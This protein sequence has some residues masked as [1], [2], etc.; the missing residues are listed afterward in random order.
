MRRTGRWVGEIKQMTTWAVARRQT[1]TTTTLTP[2]PRFIVP[3]FHVHDCTAPTGTPPPRWARAHLGSGRPEPWPSRRGPGRR[4][5][6][7]P[8]GAP[9]LRRRQG[10]ARV[11]EGVCVQA[12]EGQPHPL[13]RRGVLVTNPRGNECENKNLT[14]IFFVW[15]L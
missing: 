6:Q 5:P 4:A 11:G 2:L 9:L 13:R 7:G 8:R 3:L 1:T 15:K 10:A 12:L 14:F